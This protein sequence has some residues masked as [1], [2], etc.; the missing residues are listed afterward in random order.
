MSAPDQA[1]AG[2][3]LRPMEVA[4]LPRVA[5]MEVELFGAEAWSRET[6][7]A[8][9]HAAARGDRR[10]IV[11]EPGEDGQED[12]QQDGRGSRDGRDGFPLLGYA[13]L[14][15]GDGLGDA[16]LLTLATAPAARRQGLGRLMLAELVE[17][18]R[19]AGCRAVLLEVRHSNTAARSLYLSQG[20]EPIG[21]RRRYY[22]A[23]VED[24]VVMRLGLRAST[25]PVG[26]EAT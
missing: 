21:L 24:A 20:F 7:S 2:L 1:P 22:R 8:E 12:G 17:S 26:A 14:Y 19:R 15:H 16:D 10:Y 3:S 5:R 11:V 18:A 9:L 23:P 13:G 6:L 4:D 25:G